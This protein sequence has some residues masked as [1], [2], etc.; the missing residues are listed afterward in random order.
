MSDERYESLALLSPAM[1]AVVLEFVAKLVEHGIVFKIVET[2]RTEERHRK[3]LARGA[4]W[5]AKSKHLRTRESA[6]GET[7]P[8]SDAIDL[9]PFD[10]WRLSGANKIMWDAEN[11]QWWRMGKLG[12]SLWLIWGGR[13]ARRD[14]GHWELPDV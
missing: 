11:P 12:E 6:S 9:A 1:R 10:V 5:T 2:W 7:V 14:M 4:S 8:A 3:L 13:W